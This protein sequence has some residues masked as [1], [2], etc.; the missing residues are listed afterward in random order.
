ML[1]GR[2]S[3]KRSSDVLGVFRR[4]TLSL[5]AVSLKQT[6]HPS[7]VSSGAIVGTD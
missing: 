1:K 3:V 5:R 4:Y 6:S 7:I 2:L